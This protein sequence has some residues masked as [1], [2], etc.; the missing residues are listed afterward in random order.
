MPEGDGFGEVDD[1][2]VCL[3]PLPTPQGSTLALLKVNAI[4]CTTL[5]RLAPPPV[6]G[7]V[8]LIGQ[9][10]L[11]PAEGATG[12]L[13]AY[14]ATGGRVV[15]LEQ[16]NPLRYQGLN[17]AEIEVEHNIG[18]VAFSEDLT[19]P[20]L[21]GLKDKDFFTWEPGEIVYRNAYVKPQR[22]AKS[23][24]QCN[25]SLTNSALVE[26]HGSVAKMVM[27]PRERRAFLQG[28]HV[29]LLAVELDGCG[30]RGVAA[31]AGN[32]GNLAWLDVHPVLHLITDHRHQQFRAAGPTEI[33]RQRRGLRAALLDSLVQS[34]AL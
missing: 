34:G 19:H 25:E 29:A 21:R 24:L 30:L 31:L 9:D 3:W 4:S 27:L 33:D 2:Q 11:T 14:A 18:R 6:S 17:P 13:V 23:L 1:G 28:H 20:I 15:V 22:G 8:W 26:N 10:A 32:V 16:E 5:N 12:L 7:K